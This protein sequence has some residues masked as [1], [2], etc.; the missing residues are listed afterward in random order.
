MLGNMLAHMLA[1]QLD[2]ADS[3][4]RYTGGGVPKGVVMMIAVALV[5]VL[6]SML[7]WKRQ[8]RRRWKITAINVLL[9]WT[10]IGWIVA[11]V[12]TFAYEPPSEG[13]APDQEHVPQG[14]RPH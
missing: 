6:P 8:S 12:L 4:S 2:P 13:D 5:Y 11:M 10:V 3:V 7:A 1:L 14:A 9:G